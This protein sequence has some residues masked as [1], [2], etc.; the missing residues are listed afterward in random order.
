[1]VLLAG[2]SSP[3]VCQN[4][5]EESFKVN[6]VGTKAFIK[7]AL[8]AGA[9]VLFASS[10]TVYGEQ[11]EPV[12][13]TSLCSPIGRYGQMKLE[14]EEAFRLSSNFGVFRLAYVVGDSDRFTNFLKSQSG[15][16]EEVDA[17]SDLLRNTISINVVLEGLL[18]IFEDWTN[19]GKPRVINFGG[20]ISESRVDLALR[21]IS[22]QR[23]NLRVKAV[24]APLGFFDFRPRV[25]S[26]SNKKLA[27]LLERL[28]QTNSIDGAK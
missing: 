16:V 9:R 5:F 26:I 18:R 21:I 15:Q 17:Y 25:I 10:D 6:V 7:T 20:P 27:N 11:P 19:L 14:V 12:E 3:E 4:E 23:L 1:V 13:E 2:E 28:G 8:N 22:E 24:S